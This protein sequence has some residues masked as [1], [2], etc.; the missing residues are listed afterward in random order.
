MIRPYRARVFYPGVGWSVF[1]FLNMEFRDD[2][3][4]DKYDEKRKV[5]VC[6]STLDAWVD[7]KDLIEK[8]T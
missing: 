5:E 4:R 3:A 1:K 7:F 2:F 6:N 8:I